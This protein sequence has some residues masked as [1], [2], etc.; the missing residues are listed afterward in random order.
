MKSEETSWERGVFITEQG[1]IIRLE[2]KSMKFPQPFHPEFPEGYKFRWI[3]YNI[4]NP[5]E[6]VRIDNHHG[7][8]LHF[9]IDD[10]QPGQ[11]LPWV[12]LEKTRQFFFEKVYQRFGFFDYE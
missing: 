4:E 8:S 6:S 1:Y 12:S 5:Q 10:E 2:M 11:P 7:K 9:H 3:V